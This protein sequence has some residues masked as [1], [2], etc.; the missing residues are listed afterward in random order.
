[1]SIVLSTVR[2]EA[3]KQSDEIASN[4]NDAL[5]SLVD[6]AKLQTVLFKNNVK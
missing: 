4:T 1:M 3:K 2:S 5:N 6:L